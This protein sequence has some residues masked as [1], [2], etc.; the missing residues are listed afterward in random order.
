MQ[1]IKAVR[2][3][4]FGAVK[5]KKPTPRSGL[6]P[7]RCAGILMATRRTLEMDSP[8]HRSLGFASDPLGSFALFTSCADLV[9][10]LKRKRN[11]VVTEAAWGVD[12]VQ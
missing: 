6:L 7:E 11:A 4:S 9:P 2:E 8:T 12:I 1:K 10:R 5:I 3:I